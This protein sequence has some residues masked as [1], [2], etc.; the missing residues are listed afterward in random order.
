WDVFIGEHEREAMTARFHRAAPDFPAAEYE[1][2]FTNARGDDLVIAWRSAPL[3]D[4]SGRVVGITVGGL[5][6]TERKR[7]EEDIRASRSRPDRGAR[8]ARGAQP[9]AGRID[10][11]RPPPA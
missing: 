6:I 8:G 7:H 1:N 4:E 2:V 3:R 9:A 5:D 11:A 10:D